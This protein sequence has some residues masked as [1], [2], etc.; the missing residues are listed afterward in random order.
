MSYNPNFVGQP[1]ALSVGST[2]TGYQNGTVSSMSV[3]T[4][5]SANTTSGHM[6]LTDVSNE[7]TTESWLGLT[8]QNIPSTAHGLVASS[9]RIENIP[10]GLGFAIGDTLW[11]GTA[12]GSLTNIKPDITVSGWQT[13]YFVLFVGVVVQNEFNSVNQDIQLCRQIIGQL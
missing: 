4:S 1:A 9:G 13:G 7:A 5:V 8:A 2:Q 10:L 6:V 12:P 11:V 3:G